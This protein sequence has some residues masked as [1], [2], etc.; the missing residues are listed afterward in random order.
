LKVSEKTKRGKSCVIVV[1]EGAVDSVKDL[2]LESKG[3]DK[4][5]N[6]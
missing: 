6:K 5:G 1:A 3:V 2:H 4:S